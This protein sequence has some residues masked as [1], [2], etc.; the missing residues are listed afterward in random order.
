MTFSL[1]LSKLKVFNSSTKEQDYRTTVKSNGKADIDSLIASAS[2]NI[3][4]HKAELR[5]A[6]ELMLDAI[7]NAL[8]SG[9]NVELLL[10]IGLSVWVVRNG[11]RN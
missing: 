7:G 10:N 4:M 9:K 5:M 6:F 1:K 8:T 2:K 3:A 11:F